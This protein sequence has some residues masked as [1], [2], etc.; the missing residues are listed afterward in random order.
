MDTRKFGKTG[1]MSSIAILGGFVFS[2]QTTE[3]ADAYLHFA[4]DCGV[5]HIDIAP[6]Y[7]HAEASVG[8]ALGK[9]R[10]KFFLGCK[11]TERNKDSA[12]R[13]LRE[14]LQRLHTEHFD[15]YQIHAVTSMEELDQ[16]TR[17]GGALEAMIAAQLEGV[18]KN[19][20]ITG[21]GVDS[22]IVF[23][24]ALRRFDFA[25]VLFPINFVQYAD[26]NY[27]QQA[28][29]LLKMCI[30]KEVGVMVIKS[31]TKGPWGN[32][33]PE[34]ITWYEPFTDTEMILKAQNFALSQP[35]VTGICTSGSPLVFK[36]QIESANNY[37]PMTVAEQEEL[38][39]Q[40]DNYSPLFT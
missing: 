9:L 22:P 36:Q 39:R 12:A 24:E 17:K 23:Q 31:I 15:L 35:G 25:S 13:E 8:P 2:Q 34:H 5:N 20:G 33:T 11:T 26:P 28:T 6:S 29:D 27:R 16:A 14:S 21:H 32:H 37:S 3:E 19:I 18:V 7:G 4:L 10:D 38:I 30:E 40:A 1:H